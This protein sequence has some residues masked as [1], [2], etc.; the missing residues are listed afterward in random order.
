M[1]QNI[2]KEEVTRNIAL[3]AAVI[4]ASIIVFSGIQSLT[5]L[6]TDQTS[7]ELENQHNRG[8][9]G[10]QILS[11]LMNIELE[12]FRIAN[13]RDER[14]LAVHK[15]SADHELNE[16]KNILK[17][18]REGGEYVATY[19]VNFDNVNEIYE[20]I[21]YERHSSGYVVE[22]IN[23]MPKVMDIG[24]LL[25]TLTENITFNPSYSTTS[26]APLDIYAD[27]SLKQ[28][29]ASLK[30][31]REQANRIFYEA[32]NTIQGLE[33]KLEHTNKW[34]FILRL[35]LASVLS[36]I[37]LVLFIRIFRRIRLIIEER[38][39]KT[40]LLEES[41]ETFKRIFKSLPV[42][43]VIL[44]ADRKVK[45]L[46]SEALKIFEADSADSVYG[47]KCKELFCPPDR[48]I[49]PFTLKERE[50]H[51]GEV[52]LRTLQNNKVHVL[53]S[54][55]AIPLNGEP[56]VLEA[57]MD[58]S[59][60]R[61]VEKLLNESRNFLNAVFNSVPAG[62]F[63]I[64][65]EEH[66]I[67]DANDSALQM[68]GRPREEVIGGICHEYIC[69]IQKGNCPFDE[70]SGETN[71][72]RQL[73]T[74]DG[75]H[76]DILK[77]V[78]R[79]EHEGRSC[80]VE[81]FVDI[82][83]RKQ[84]EQV[85]QQAREVA[86]KANLAKSEFLA[87]MSHE[88]RTPMNAVSGLSSLLLKTDLDHEQKEWIKTILTTSRSLAGIVN[89]IIDLSRIEAG[90]LEI[91]QVPFDLHDLSNRPKQL[92]EFQA[93]EKELFFKVKIDER[94]PSQL[95]GDPLRINQIL[96][97]LVNNA[98]KFTYSGGITLEVSLLSANENIAQVRFAIKDTGIGLNADQTD[99]LFAPFSQ[100]A[101]P[102]PYQEGAGLGLTICKRLVSK[103]NGT[104]GVNSIQ[105]QGS[106]FYFTLPLKRGTVEQ[107]L[108]LNTYEHMKVLAADDSRSSRNVLTKLLGER[109]AYV[110]V[111]EGGKT[112]VFKVCQEAA[113]QNPYDLVLLDWRM[114]DCDGIDAAH[115]IRSSLEAM[116]QPIIFLISA[117]AEKNL[118]TQNDSVGIDGFLYKPLNE[119]ALFAEI[120]KY[121]N[122][123]KTDTRTEALQDSK[124]KTDSISAKD[125]SILVAEDN[126]INMKVISRILHD[127]GY[128][129]FEARDGQTALSILDIEQIDIVLMDIRMPGMNGIEAVQ[130]IRQ[131][132]EYN[133]LPVI[134]MTAQALP[135][136]RELCIEAGMTD[137]VTKPID[138]DQFLAMLQKY[139]GQKESIILRQD[140][141]SS[142]LVIKGIETRHAIQRMHNDLGLYL[143]ILREYYFHAL[144]FCFRDT[145]LMLALAPNEIADLFHSMNGTAAHIGANEIH[146]ESRTIEIAIRDKGELP[147]EDKI[148]SFKSSLLQQLGDINLFFKSDSF[149]QLASHCPPSSDEALDEYFEAL[150]TCCASDTC[151][152][153]HVFEALSVLQS[154]N[155]MSNEE[156]IQ[157]V[158]KTFESKDA[159]MF[160]EFLN[161]PS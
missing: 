120:S 70:S 118:L 75:T 157:R 144:R 55:L 85:L 122:C 130:A 128:K 11:K 132:K 119:A 51:E 108:P 76:I 69:P 8:L 38:A 145:S 72:E 26:P 9:L 67:I 25:Q 19:P 54:A 62:V 78:V 148:D 52:E 117:Y 143:D 24:D 23:I 65:A 53:K 124:E 16:L 21:V 116:D 138:P 49:C 22:V 73:I 80:F 36:L 103:M 50:S 2:L 42:G 34:F 74:A 64:D 97:N 37:S 146:V 82:T 111:V 156:L 104:I 20:H 31:S 126:I 35:G 41:F 86:E 92:L 59:R 134:A 135:G 125:V 93:M 123:K 6:Y 14:E 95:M 139:H 87:H 10:K 101:K 112:A 61:R 3:L 84:S 46:N 71:M 58:I 15:R 98:L 57:F 129:T 150:T 91:Q 140:T 33:K 109:F 56:V 106:E 160:L 147:T 151:D 1:F 77:S 159:E 115:Q 40:A 88:I 17:V 79:I 107:S 142:I 131:K 154:T 127:A 161:S 28:L 13:S 27:L 137:Y 158:S 83:A 44:D 114:A 5:V 39:E 7:Q 89:D 136:D 99:A 102:D 105:G 63:V 133:N 81:S 45:M 68:V 110:D 30:R 153:T 152:K 121:L 12:V 66:R 60:R 90:K 113:N 18:L 94:I 100:P 4:I 155:A 29:V 48:G 141:D 149:A 47:K 32:G 43:L 96:V